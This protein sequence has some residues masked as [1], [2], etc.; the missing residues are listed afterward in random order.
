MYHIFCIHSSVEGHL[1]SFQF[2]AIINKAALLKCSTNFQTS[3]TNWIL[4]VQTC[5]YNSTGYPTIP[6][7]VVNFSDQKR[8]GRK[9]YLAFVSRPQ[10]VI[11]G[12]Q[13]RDSRQ[14]SEAK[15]TKKCCLPAH[16]LVH[17]QAQP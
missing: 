3:A 15:I 10:F 1:G 6:V 9:A 2:L 16:S 8:W 11:E 4:V 5:N 13:G 7:A 14:E 17:L 12:S